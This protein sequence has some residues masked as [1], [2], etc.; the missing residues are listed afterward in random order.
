MVALWVPFPHVAW[1]PLPMLI[2]PAFAGCPCLCTWAGLPWAPPGGLATPVGAA[3][4]CGLAVLGH[5]LL[6]KLAALLGVAW[7][8][9]A[10]LRRRPGGL[11]G[12]G[13]VAYLHG[14]ARPWSA[15]VGRLH[16]CCWPLVLP[17]KWPVSPF[18]DTIA[19]RELATLLKLH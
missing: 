19:S 17:F 18:S 4:A 8:L 2:V 13:L 7:L 3:C 6:R 1:L 15:S 12:A 10:C 5:P 14:L 16:L 9:V 11:A